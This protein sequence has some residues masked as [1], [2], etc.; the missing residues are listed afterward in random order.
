M[1]ETGKQPYGHNID[2]KD[3][4]LEVRHNRTHPEFGMYAV[5]ASTVETPEVFVKYPYFPDVDGVVIRYVDSDNQYMQL[6]KEFAQQHS[7]D[8][9]MPNCSVVVKNGEVIGIGANG[10][11]YHDNHGCERIRLGSKTGQDYDKCEGCHPKNHGEQKAITDALSRLQ[12]EDLV[13]SEIYL[14]GHWWLCE[15]CW[16]AMLGC[17][18]KTANLLED[19]QVLFNKEHPDNI[20]G[21]QFET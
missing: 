5:L 11:D 3:D 12:A 13:G 16:G 2:Y 18:I 1:S 15:S 10:S 20:I 17:G 7:L 19:S 9:V 4:G 21:K 14:W 6:A 8:K